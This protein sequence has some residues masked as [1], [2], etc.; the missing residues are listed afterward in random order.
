MREIEIELIS[1]SILHNREDLVQFYWR[2]TCLPSTRN[3]N[4]YLICL[5]DSS[6]SFQ[7]KVTGYGE[8]NINLDEEIEI[9]GVE[10]DASQY[11]AFNVSGSGTKTI[12]HTVV[13]VPEPAA[14][15]LLGLGAGALL[16]KKKRRGPSQYDKDGMIL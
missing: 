15:T 6:L 11:G 3:A 2:Y 4:T 14:L 12:A 13:Y 5:S 10:G 16:A 9:N 8:L 7:C 1:D